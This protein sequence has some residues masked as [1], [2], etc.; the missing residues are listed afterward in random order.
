M[1]GLGFARLGF[2]E[3]GCTWRG[4]DQRISEKTSRNLH[5]A[6]RHNAVTVQS[7]QD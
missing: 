7:A 2:G 1:Q 5:C 6:S 4:P 3:L